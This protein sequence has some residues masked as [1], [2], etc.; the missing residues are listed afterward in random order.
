MGCQTGWAMQTPPKQGII[1]GLVAFSKQASG[2]MAIIGETLD[3]FG[4]AQE[5]VS[6]QYLIL[7]RII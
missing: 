5:G 1:L 2:L 3:G 4:H 7:A 6:G